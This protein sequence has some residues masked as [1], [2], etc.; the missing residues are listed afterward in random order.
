MAIQEQWAELLEPGLRSIF[1]QQRDALVAESR[2]PMLFE[3]A[4]STKAEEKMLGMGGM[5]DWEEYKGTIEYDDF[6]KGFQATLSHKEYVSGFKVERSLVDDDQ[7][8]VI[9]RRPRQL[10]TGAVRTREKHAASVFN[11]AFDSDYTGPD[12]VALCASTHDLSPTKTSSHQSNAGSTAF[13]YD[14][15][16]ATRQAMREFTDDRGE[17]ISVNPDT[18]LIPP[19]LEDEAYTVVEAMGKPGTADNDPNFVRS[20]VNRVV[21]WDYLTDANNW[22]MIDSQLARL[23]N[24][25]FD[26]VPLEFEMDPTSDFR[27]E[28]RFRGYMRYSYGWSDWKWVYGHEVT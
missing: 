25:W 15:V 14:A 28:A 13:S 17:L 12:S 20:Q 26:R 18:I 9:N 22:F 16:I 7:Y 19:E 1:Q 11:N 4:T 23:Y 2:I 8:G 24:H 21:V 27:L 5:G 6:E 3:V 10:A